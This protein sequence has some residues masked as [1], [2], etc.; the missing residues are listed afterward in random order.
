MRVHPRYHSSI[1]YVEPEIYGLAK[2]NIHYHEL[3]TINNMLSYDFKV[4]DSILVK[5][6]CGD[7]LTRDQNYI[8]SISSEEV[9]TFFY[10]NETTNLTKIQ[11]DN[12]YHTRAYVNNNSSKIKFANKG[13]MVKSSTLKS[14][15]H[16]KHFSSLSWGASTSQFFLDTDCYI[17]E[18][19]LRGD[20]NSV[21]SVRKESETEFIIP[22]EILEDE[23]FFYPTQPI[24]LKTNDKLIFTSNSPNSNVTF[25]INYFSDGI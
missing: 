25:K 16:Q 2:F 22:D 6:L 1:N 4:Q 15:L 14:M 3:A 19:S 10:F 20:E 7:V 23:F 17:D 11:T 21:V 9:K 8:I 5:N 13:G 24:L 18:I 12:A